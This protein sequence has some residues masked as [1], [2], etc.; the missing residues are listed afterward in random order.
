MM[1]LKNTKTKTED[2]DCG[3]RSADRSPRDL[4]GGYWYDNGDDVG[5][6]DDEDDGATAMIFLGYHYS[7]HSYSYVRLALAARRCSTF[8]TLSRHISTAIFYVPS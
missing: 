5:D 6:N 8:P 2:E 3:E 4:T 7:S 1:L